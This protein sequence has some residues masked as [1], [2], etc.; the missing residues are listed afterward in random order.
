MSSLW[1]MS[2]VGCGIGGAC[3][4]ERPI[5]GLLIQMGWRRAYR[6][7]QRCCWS[8]HHSDKAY[9]IWHVSAISLHCLAEV[10]VGWHSGANGPLNTHLHS[11][12][13]FRSGGHHLVPGCCSRLSLFVSMCVWRVS[14]LELFCDVKKVCTKS[15]VRLSVPGCYV[16]LGFRLI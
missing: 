2:L 13:A 11:S 16:R 9:Q 3:A 10:S 7:Q 15:V 14:F 12:T 5:L 6:V 8:S 4:A 1:V